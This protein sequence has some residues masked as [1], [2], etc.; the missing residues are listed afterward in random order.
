MGV[1][2]LKERSVKYL[3]KDFQSLKRDLIRFSQAHH[4][5]VFQ[6]YNESS[7]G[8]AV[9]EFVAM[10]VDLLSYYQDAQFE[11][12]RQE[13]ARQI[14]NVVSFAKSQ[15]YRPSGKRA[16]RTIQTFFIEVPA[17]TQNGESVP[18]DS[19]S[20]ILRTGT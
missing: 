20:G 4:S 17:T 19:Y 8:M 5:G 13:N 16:A 2:F 15:G 12:V 7:P 1:D 6:D 11:E 18:N 9:L 10:A 14:E 3:G